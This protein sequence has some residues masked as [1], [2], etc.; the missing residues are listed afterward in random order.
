M[1]IFLAAMLQWSGIIF[2][3]TYG[4]MLAKDIEGGEIS[5]VMPSLIV[6]CLVFS[7]IGSYFLLIRIGR[8]PIIFVGTIVSFFANMLIAIG[9]INKDQING[10]AIIYFGIFVFIINFG[11]TIGPVIW[12]YIP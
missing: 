1:S 6:L 7:T 10:R 12:L 9:F 2:V 4:Q 5:K 8:R 11:L 3:L